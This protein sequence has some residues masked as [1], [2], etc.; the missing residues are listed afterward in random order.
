MSATYFFRFDEVTPPGVRFYVEDQRYDLDV[1]IPIDAR[2]SLRA[3]IDA[4]RTMDAGTY[5]EEQPVDAWEL[6]RRVENHPR[7]ADLRRWAAWPL[8]SDDADMAQLA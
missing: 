8:L 5:P 7:L 2:F 6:H 3:I 4:F 1:D